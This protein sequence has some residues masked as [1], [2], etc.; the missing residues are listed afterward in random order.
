M[1]S[2]VKIGTRLIISFSV[3]LILMVMISGLSML[4]FNNINKKFHSITEVK[5]PQTL[6]LNDIQGQI[7]DVARALRNAIILTDSLQSKKELD[8]IAT[9]RHNVDKDLEQLGSMI[10][11]SEGKV[12]LETIKEKRKAYAEAQKETITLLESG[13]K[14][15]A[16]Q[17][18]VGK[19][20]LQQNGYFGSVDKMKD[21]LVKE[22]QNA[23]NAVELTHKSATLVNIILLAASLLITVVVCY[24]TTTSITVPLRKAVQ[25]NQSVA[26]GDL[27][28]TV[29][30][31]RKD[32]IGQLNESALRMVE[33]LRG[34][35]GNLARTSD[36]VA[37]AA[38]QLNESSEQIATA[39]EKVASQ[40]GNVATAG[41]EM[42][43]TSGDIAQNCNRAAESAQLAT[44]VATEGSAVVKL[45]VDVMK[46]ITDKVQASAQ[47]VAGL[48]T[49]SD[50]IG[51]IIGTIEDIADQTNLLALN[52]AIEAARAGEQGRGFAVVADEVRALAE[53]T[54]LATKEIGEMIRNIQQETKGAVR[55][56]EEGVREVENGTKEAERSGAS[57]QEILDQINEVATQVNQIATAAEEQTAT[58]SEISSNIHQMSEV[59][60]Q[61]ARGA[62]DSS[63]SAGMLSRL[64]DELKVV[65]G[66]F[67]LT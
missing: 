5:Y 8:R 31:D 25:V 24:L 44:N 26:D 9:A 51:K 7:N 40:A 16:A 12:L 37:A 57:L 50:Q 62:Q 42:A 14:E 38:Y 35:I 4:N 52:A 64:A 15:D 6:I 41:E 11:S 45:T 34:L 32:E 58:T 30:I 63:Q 17:V 21:F 47:T 65:I 29:V 19:L 2:N 13:K 1:F 33:N 20:R 60:Q 66:K 43:A 54:T 22:V 49:R 55:T 46:R 48:G 23:T 18:L 3:M 53:R 27:S 67:N 10:D 28:V 59:V 36:Q 56:M 61:T 39:S